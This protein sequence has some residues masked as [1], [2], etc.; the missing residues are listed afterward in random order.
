MPKKGCG[1]RNKLRGVK[2]GL[3]AGLM[4]S[5]RRL[6][7][8]ARVR[9]T[10]INS[11]YMGKG[12][13]AFENNH[14]WSM[15][16]NYAGSG[17]APLDEALEAIKQE[18]ESYKTAYKNNLKY[19]KEVADILVHQYNGYLDDNSIP[20]E[21]A[22]LVK[23]R[24]NLV[25][26]SHRDTFGI[27]INDYLPTILFH[28]GLEGDVESIHQVGL[29]EVSQI[30]DEIIAEWQR[31]NPDEPKFNTQEDFRAYIDGKFDEI[32]QR[33]QV[34]VVT[35]FTEEWAKN[36]QVFKE[37][38]AYIDIAYTTLEQ[39]FHKD[40]IAKIPPVT[41]VP[42]YDPTNGSAWYDK[43]QY[44]LNYATSTW[45]ADHEA[46]SRHEASPGH[47]LDISTTNDALTNNAVIEGWGLYSEDLAP[48]DLNLVK[49]K[50]P[51][52]DETRIKYSRIGMLF[53]DLFRAVRLVVDTAIHMNKMSKEEAE[54]YMRKYTIMTEADIKSE[55]LRYS[56]NPGQA[57]SYK[58]GQYCLKQY[59][60][61][62]GASDA[63]GN[64]IPN[65]PV[66][67]DFHDIILNSLDLKDIHTK[68]VHKFGKPLPS[69][70]ELV[71]A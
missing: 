53:S 63:T 46:T 57:L 36:T 29:R 9:L 59:R 15:L 26:G 5:P 18:N 69:P 31:M 68:L 52:W 55:V 62:I 42:V 22:A 37:N 32:T 66:L 50:L 7:E 70:E 39:F 12:Y 56:S 58:I 61:L 19:N 47:H 67:F 28:T 10:K 2:L 45:N 8:N 64:A 13:G 38:Q 71:A 30:Y 21:I 54:E 60:A 14:Q 43:N 24:L 6:K 16:I 48:Y 41:L 44:F 27:G 3:L 33:N 49:A 35:P 40:L 17:W 1:C 51:D 11:Q 4:H 65:S 23:E 34:Q 25:A 20:R